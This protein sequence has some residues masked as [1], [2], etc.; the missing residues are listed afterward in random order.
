M[1]P[2]G[3]EPMTLPSL[4]LLREEMPFE[5]RVYWRVQCMLL[6]RKNLSSA[7]EAHKQISS[8]KLIVLIGVLRKI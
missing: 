2:M 7:Q 8:V 6:W 3:L 5:L 1:H 4:P